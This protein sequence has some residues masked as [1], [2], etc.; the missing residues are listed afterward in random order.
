MESDGLDLVLESSDESDEDGEIELNKT[1]LSPSGGLHNDAKVSD[2]AITCEVDAAS[3]EEELGN[4][5]VSEEEVSYDEDIAYEEKLR[6]SSRPTKTL[7]F[8]RQV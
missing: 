7:T 6:R 1:Y 5:K 2:D 3:H 4:Y 8:I